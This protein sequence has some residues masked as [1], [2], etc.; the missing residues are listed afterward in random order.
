MVGEEIHAPPAWPMEMTVSAVKPWSEVGLA[1]GAAQADAM[2]QAL[3][4]SFGGGPGAPGLGRR[5]VDLGSGRGSLCFR[6][7]ERAPEARLLGLEPSAELLAVAES[8]RRIDAGWRQA[9]TFRQVELPIADLAEGAFPTGFTTLVSQYL[10]H[11][12][13]DL[14]PLWA[15]LRQLGAPGAV[16]MV[17]DLLRPLDGAH[18][19]ALIAR[20]A[21]AL[22]EADRQLLARAL[23]AAWP[24]DQLEQQ[25]QQSGLGCL[26]VRLSGPLHVD[27]IGR[28]P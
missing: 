6:L 20:H 19:E 7:A 5:I 22:P 11:R 25:L 26:Q 16:V 24:A 27:I 3:V 4:E 14:R 9:I 2:V 21:Q 13:S 18:A 23:A 10:L 17:R 28:L 15:T 1:V 8:R 12:L